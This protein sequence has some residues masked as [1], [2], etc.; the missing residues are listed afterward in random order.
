MRTINRTEMLPITRR[1]TV[2]DGVR[3]LKEKFLLQPDE[4]VTI[5][6][7]T[8]DS[9]EESIPNRVKHLKFVIPACVQV[10]SSTDR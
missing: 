6:I 1:M 8:E 5:I 7:E 10:P 2:E 9:E 4:E 3:L